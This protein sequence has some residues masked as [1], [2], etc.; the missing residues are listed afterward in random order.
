MLKSGTA[1]TRFIQYTEVYQILTLEAQQTSIIHQEVI[2]IHSH[3]CKTYT[4]KESIHSTVCLMIALSALPKWVLHRVR[5]NASSFTC[6]YPLV[7]ISSTSSCLMSFSLSSHHFYRSF[8]PSSFPSI[9]CFR[10]QFLCNMLPIQLG[11][12]LFIVCKIILPSFS[13]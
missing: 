4:D 1:T 11:S 7:S 2:T 9:P 5:S 10:R 13:S 6:Q 8:L 12:L 3:F